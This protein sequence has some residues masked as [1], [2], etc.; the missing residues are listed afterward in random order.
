MR[1]PVTFTHALAPAQ[2]HWHVIGALHR[3]EGEGYRPPA[4]GNKD[5]VNTVHAD[6]VQT[7]HS[8]YATPC[9]GKTHNGAISN[10][11]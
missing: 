6:L 7:S 4:P 3:G 1:P 5:L 2:H 8:G 11:L 10:S 9:G